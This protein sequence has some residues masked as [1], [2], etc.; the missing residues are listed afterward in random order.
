MAE[1]PVDML[2]LVVLAVGLVGTYWFSLRL[3]LPMTC[4]RRKRLLLSLRQQ[5]SQCGLYLRDDFAFEDPVAQAKFS[6][7]CL[8]GGNLF[9]DNLAVCTKAIGTY[10]VGVLAHSSELSASASET[11]RQLVQFWLIM[12]VLRG[13]AIMLLGR[14]ASDMVNVWKPAWPCGSGRQHAMY[15]RGAS[16]FSGPG[17]PG[18]AAVA[19]DD[20]H[21]LLELHRPGDAS[22]FCALSHC[23][24]GA[25]TVHVDG[26]NMQP[27]ELRRAQSGGAVSPAGGVSHWVCHRHHDYGAD[28]KLHVV[29]DEDIATDSGV[30]EIQLKPTGSHID[31]LESPR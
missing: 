7:Y 19:F 13:S 11:V 30:S 31:R 21:H 23:P 6:R 15:K 2:W 24:G 28:G 17:S 12:V 4:L 26:H 9:W 22:F 10:V 5:A 16:R 25:A 1:T 14:K 27:G 29:E 3:V 18:M 20:S 8:V